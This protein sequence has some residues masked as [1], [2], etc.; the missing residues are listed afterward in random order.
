MVRAALSWVQFL[1]GPGLAQWSERLYPGFRVQFLHGPGLA[2]WSE[3][4][5]PGFRVQFL[6]GQLLHFLYSLLATLS[7]FS[8]AKSLHELPGELTVVEEV[9]GVGG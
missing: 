1:H 6:H 2:Q 9:V 5:Y 7:E 3:R 4:L 8:A